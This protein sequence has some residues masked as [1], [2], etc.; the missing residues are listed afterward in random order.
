MCGICGKLSWTTPPDLAVV[1]RMA[2]RLAHRG[3][4]AD[5]FFARGPI[6][7]GHRRLSII[8]PSAASNQPM[9]DRGGNLTLVFNGEIY[10]FRELRRELE[11]LGSGFATS[12]DTEVILESYRHWG[13]AC[14]GRLQGMFAFALW[15]EPRRRLLLARD[16]LGK[17]P[18]FLFPLAD[19]GVV[20]ASELKGLIE[21]PEVPRRLN[22]EALG[23]YLSLSYT[24]TAVPI[25]AG[26]VKLPPAHFLLLEESKAAAPRCYWDLARYFREKRSFVSEEEAAEALSTQLD[27]AVRSRLVADVP[28]GAFLSGGLDSSAIV[29]AMARFQGGEQVHTFSVG[30]AE[31]SYSELPEAQAAAAL[32]RVHHHAQTV[33]PTP[34]ELL[35]EIVWAAD[36]PFADTS[37]IPTYLLA[38]HTRERVTVALSGDGGDELF[39]GYETYV[40][41]RLHGM[42]AQ[43]PAALPRAARWVAERILPASRAKVSFDYKVKKLLAGSHLASGR[44]HFFWRTIFSQEEHKSL[45]PDFAQQLESVDAYPYFE[46]FENEVAACHPLDRASYVDL[47]TWLPDDIL[48]K[49]DRMSM[50]HSLEARAPFL[51]HRL[52]E[53]AAGL[54]PGWKLKGW[55]KK[56]LL[57]KSQ[58]RHLPR[59]ITHRKKAGFNAPVAHWLAGDWQSLLTTE[60]WSRPSPALPVAHKVVLRMAEE[61]RQGKADHSLKLLSLIHLRLWAERIRLT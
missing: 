39:A 27:D 35:Q 33:A 23:H 20:F 40:A 45:F 37:M 8:E 12:S 24:L 18:L 54:P 30:F 46:R 61:H 36:E 28:L 2:T 7:L 10:N 26:V 55:E 41:N 25:L 42:L 60:R 49:V 48:V 44:A 50:A 34:A 17:K 5:G 29:A 14:L 9:T 47:K 52:V 22:P 13:P 11:A 3:P 31:R 6:A 4:D 58:A 16:R 1:A 56:Y 15:D 51:D 43:L 59:A 19:G 57:K 21:D 53:L 32:L 38:R